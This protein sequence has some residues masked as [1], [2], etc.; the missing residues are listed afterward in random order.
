M[1]SIRESEG[2]NGQSFA[3]VSWVD[4]TMRATHT[5]HQNDDSLEEELIE[6]LPV[7]KIMIF[8]H[9]FTMAKNGF[10]QESHGGLYDQMD[11]AHAVKVTYG[12]IDPSSGIYREKSTSRSVTLEEGPDRTNPI[13]LTAEFQYDPGH[14]FIQFELV[15]SRNGR[16]VLHKMINLLDLPFNN[17][18]TRR[19]LAQARNSQGNPTPIEQSQM[20]LNVSFY[21]EYIKPHDIEISP[22]QKTLTMSY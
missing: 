14:N 6:K 13:K 11:E 8:I 19:I 4:Y 22:L 17:F 7:G 5:N 18:S 10:D 1:F 20:H 21:I 16:L 9:D 12:M 15:N 3:D 2:E